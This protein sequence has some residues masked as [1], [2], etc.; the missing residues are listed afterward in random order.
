MKFAETLSLK[1]FANIQLITVFSFS[2]VIENNSMHFRV[3]KGSIVKPQMRLASN[4][5]LFQL[6]KF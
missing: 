6:V 5:G 1:T 4:K 2:R 3:K